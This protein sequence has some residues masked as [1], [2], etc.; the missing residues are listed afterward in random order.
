MKSKSIESIINMPPAEFNSFLISEFLTYEMPES[1]STEEER[2]EA[3]RVFLRISPQIS[4]LSALKIHAST[5]KRN[6]ANEA[7]SAKGERKTL[8]KMMHGELV[9]KENAILACLNDLNRRYETISR[10]LAMEEFQFKM[11]SYLDYKCGERPSKR[12]G[13][14]Q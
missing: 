12:K 10:A 13:G 4:Y 9:D 8:L 3:E 2:K 14:R 6:T 5:K 7:A 11:D 1:L